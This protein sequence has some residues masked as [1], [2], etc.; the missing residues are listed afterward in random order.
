[1]VPFL[2]CFQIPDEPDSEGGTKRPGSSLTEREVV[3]YGDMFPSKKP[4]P[5]KEL[6]VKVP[7]ATTV[8]LN[9]QERRPPKVCNGVVLDKIYS[10]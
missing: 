7:T 4:K 6:V 9:R 5:A 3:D 1:M 2:F 8:Q 10:C